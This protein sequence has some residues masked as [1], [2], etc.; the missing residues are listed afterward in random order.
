MDILTRLELELAGLGPWPSRHAYLFGDAD[1]ARAALV[2]S[3]NLT[4][5][6]MWRNPEPG[7]EQNLQRLSQISGHL[8]RGGL[9]KSF[10]V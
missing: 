8:P 4:S 2:T 10:S 7:H 5:A 6:G 3:A 1:D 9:I